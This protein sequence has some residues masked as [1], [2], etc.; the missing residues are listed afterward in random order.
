[1]TVRDIQRI[2]KD[3]TTSSFGVSIGTGLML[4][5]LADPTTTR[6]DP[7]REIPKRVDLTKYDGWLVNGYTLLRNIFSSITDK[8]LTLSKDV[9]QPVMDIL[10]EEILIIQSIL[11][12]SVGLGY[13]KILVPDY[14]KLIPI[15]NVNKDLEVNYIQNNLEALKL[16][17]DPL[18]AIDS[19]I[20]EVVTTDGYKLEMKY[21]KHYLLTTSFCLDLLQ[22][23]GY[24]LLESH[25]GVIKD[26]TQWYTKY[27]V[28]GT[29]DLSMLPM[30]DI[31]LY[32]LGDDQLVR[33]L[34]V[35]VK[36]ELLRIAI[37]YKWSY[38]TS[39]F[40]VKWDIDKSYILK[41]AIKDFKGY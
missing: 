37:E 39:R 19:S 5:S 21:K 40:K 10:T 17:T 23:D 15:F 33:S 11:E 25:T 34:P 8:N 2:L 22:Y 4:E 14:E 36:K 38:R 27:H 32:I 1:M 41:E 6:Y 12:T 18:K 16:F 24:D 9:I 35:K 30:V 20:V 26:I 31:V 29:Q 3:R 28:V 7:D 13:L